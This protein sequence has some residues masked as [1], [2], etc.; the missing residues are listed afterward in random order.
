MDE[1][2]YVAPMAL[3]KKVYAIHQ[4]GVDKFIENDRY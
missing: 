3:G 4:S 1:P 2:D